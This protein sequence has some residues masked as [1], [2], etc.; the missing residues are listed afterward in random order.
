MKKIFVIIAS[1]ILAVSCEG[2]LDQYPHTSITSDKAISTVDDVEYA[3]NGIYDL[4]SSAGYYGGTMFYYGDIK[5]DDVQSLYQSG[6]DTYYCYMFSH[7]SNGLHAGS[8][9]GRPWYVIRQASN[10]IAA[11]EEGKIEGDKARLN[12]LLGQAIA[13]RALAHFDLTRVFGYPYAKDNGASWG[14]PIVDHVLDITENPIRNTV[15]ECYDFIIK[16]LNRAIPLMSTA[17]DNG[18]MNQYAVRA[19]LS[20]VY[21][22]CEKNTEAFNTA[23]ALIEELKG[24]SY[25]LATNENYIAQFALENTFSSESLFE[26]ANSQ[27]DNQ[28]WDSL[29]YL[30]HWWGY[31]DMIVTLDFID[32]LDRKENWDDVRWWLVSNERGWQYWLMK[33]PGPGP[34]RWTPAV[35]NNLMVLRLSEVYLNAAE[36]GVK[37]GGDKAKA[38]EYLNAIVTRANPNKSI[39]EADFNLNTVLEERRL[40]L[41]GEGHR[42]FDALRNHVTIKR[43]GGLHLIGAPTD[44]DWDYEKCV[45]PIPVSQFELNP[46]MQQNPGYSRE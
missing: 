34:D 41:V 18:R 27:S 8:L 35:Y 15:A 6:R 45:L 24:T 11:I 23:S 46:D 25:Q 20:R 29:S 19:L 10:V 1:A 44:I 38:L 14:V 36:A 3:V 5:G 37:G 22:Y 13:T 21:L 33:Y 30:Y 16:E 40:E 7:T 26:I 4:M 12:N 17:K 43:E 31:A 39:A 9:W 2:F 32:I 42:Y 28:S